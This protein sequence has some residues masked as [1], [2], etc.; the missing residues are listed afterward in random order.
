[1]NKTGS[2]GFPIKNK[3]L[4]CKYIGKFEYSELTPD[5]EK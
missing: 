1:M 5:I 4:M 3:Y 2:L